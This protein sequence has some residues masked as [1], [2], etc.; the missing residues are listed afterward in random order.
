MY[1]FIY[2][3]G[4]PKIVRHGTPKQVGTEI[5]YSNRQTEIGTKIVF[6]TLNLSFCVRELLGVY[7]DFGL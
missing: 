2:F 5:F 4:N 6:I 3:S 1:I 7:K